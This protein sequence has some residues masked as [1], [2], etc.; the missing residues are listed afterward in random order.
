MTAFSG[1]H[2]RLALAAA[3]MLA[4]F[5]AALVFSGVLPPFYERGFSD[6]DF[7]APV[8]GLQVVDYDDLAGWAEDDPGPALET[9]M[10]SCERFE[11][12]SP[13]APANP[14]ENLGVSDP[15][16]TFAGTVADWLRPC[17]EARALLVSAYSG[18]AGRRE[19]FRAFFEFHFTPVEI[20]TVRMPLPEGP[21]RRA[22]PRIDETGT[23]TG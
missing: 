8:L 16:L 9:F 5:A 18:P 6:D 10:R 23:F 15:T 21:A 4:A 12:L 13:D 2:L 22:A 19:A 14:L 17:A 11:E 20:E 1:T 3:V 7:A